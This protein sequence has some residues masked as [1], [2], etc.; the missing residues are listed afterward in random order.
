MKELCVICKKK[1]VGWGNNPYPIKEDGK[2][3]DDC[4]T[5]KVIPARMLQK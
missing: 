1:L 4:N 2:C 3:C 5:Y